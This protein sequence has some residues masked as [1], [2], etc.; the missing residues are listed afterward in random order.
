MYHVANIP[1]A[2]T[3]GSS[4]RR[5]ARVELDGVQYEVLREER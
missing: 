1:S 4:G 3:L 2:S 5:F